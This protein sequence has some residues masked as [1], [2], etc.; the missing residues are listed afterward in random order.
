MLPQII[1]PLTDFQELCQLPARIKQL[2][3]D[4]KALR[5]QL[6]ALLGLYSQLLERVCE[7]Q[8]SL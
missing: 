4:N 8:N 2:E 6:A 3:V 7:L 5:D 1:L